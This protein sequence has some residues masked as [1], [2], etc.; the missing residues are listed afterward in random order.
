MLHN[1]EGTRRETEKQD[2]S[3]KRSERCRVRYKDSRLDVERKDL[4]TNTHLLT[5][6]YIRT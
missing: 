4:L 2:C 5:H 6:K 1:E 3:Q